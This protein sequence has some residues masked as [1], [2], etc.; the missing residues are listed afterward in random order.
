[1]MIQEMLG[2]YL[3]LFHKAVSYSRNLS[4]LK[5]LSMLTMLGVTYIHSLKVIEQVVPLDSGTL[6]YFRLLN[7]GDINRVE[8][9][10]S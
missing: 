6:G 7:P 2:K 4:N 8:G 5:T 1:M 9:D 10:N 3:C